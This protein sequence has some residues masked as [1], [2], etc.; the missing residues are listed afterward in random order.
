MAA[1]SP[2]RRPAKLIADD[3]INDAYASQMSSPT[4]TSTGSPTKRSYDGS[5]K[6]EGR[7]QEELE[8]R[9]IV[10]C[11]KSEWPAVDSVLKHLTAISPDLVDETNGYTPLMYALKDGKVARANTFIKLG[12]KVNIRA[13]DGITALHLAASHAREDMIKMLLNQK[14]DP[15][16][17]GGPKGQLPIHILSSRSS[18]S[19]PTALHLLLRSS[20]KEIRLATDRDGNIPLFMA[21]ESGSH[22]ICRE[23]LVSHGKEQVTAR[24]PGTGDTVIHMATR[25]KDLEIL[26][27]A[28]QHGGSVNAQN[29]EGLTPLHLAVIEGDETL[30]RFFHSNNAKPDIIDKHER[31]PLH[32]AAEKGHSHLVEILTDKFKASIFQR[33]KDGSTLMH[34]A[35]ESGHP[36]T[37][38]VF[39]K[40]GVPLQMPN[41][42]GAKGIHMAAAHGYVEVI[43]NL[44]HRG[45]QVDSKT[46]DNLTA[47]HA[48]TM[49]NQAEVLEILLGFG[50]QVQLKG[51][52][53]GE[54]PLHMACRTENGQKCA[55][56]LIKCG[57]DVNALTE[58]G[59]KTPL[60]IVAY[61]GFI[62]TAKLLLEE[63]EIELGLTSEDGESALHIAV[64][65]CHYGIVKLILEYWKKK[66]P[67]ETVCLLVNQQNEEGETPLH[68]AASLTKEMIHTPSE[69]R[70][71]ARVL[72][73]YGANV[74]LVTNNTSET[75]LHYCSQSG[76]VNI[77]EELVSGMSPNEMQTLCN[78]QAKDGWSP[79]LFACQAGTLAIVDFLLK[80][81]ARVDVFD[82]NGKAALHLAAEKGHNDV[83][84]LLLKYKAFINVRSKKGMTPLHMA[85]R[86][87]YGNIV[88]QIITQHGAMLDA[89]TLNKETP[90]HL[91]AERGQL[92]VCN[93]LLELKSDANALDNHGQTPLLLAAQNDH[94]EIVKLFLRHKPELVS[95]ANKDG[96]NCAHIAAMKGSV[97]VIKE[98]MK[99][100]KT[101]I[102]SAKTKSGCTPLHLAAEGGHGDVVQVL[103]QA[104]AS[105][106]EEN[107]DGYTPI[108][109]AAVHGHVSVLQALNNAVSWRIVSKKLGITALH[110][111]ASKGRSDFVREMLTQVPATLTTEQRSDNKTEDYGFTPLH[112][113]AEHGHEDVVRLLLNSAG[114][115]IDAKTQVEGSF[116]I[117]LAARG[118]HMAVVGIIISRATDQIQAKDKDGRTALHL[119]SANGHIKLV[120]LLLGQGADINATDNNG[121]SPVHYASREGY[122]DV[123]YLLTESGATPVTQTKD[124]ATPLACAA[125]TGHYNILKYLLTKEHDS[126]ALIE[127]RKFLVDIMACGKKHDNMPI[128]EFIIASPAPV[129]T[130]V[131]MARSYQL[132]AI[133]EKERSRDL[134][135]AALFCQNIAFDLLSVVS[136]TQNVGIVLRA[137]DSRNMPFLDVL[138]ELQLKEVVAHPAVQSYLS[139]QWMGNLTWATW[140]IL[141]LFLLFLVCPLSWLAFTF[142]SNH[143]YANTPIMKFMSYLV[144][145]IFFILIVCFTVINPWFPIWT[146]T[147]LYPHPHEC[148]LVIWLAGLLVANFTNPRDREGLGWIKAAI[149][150]LGICAIA[151]HLFAFIFSEDRTRQ[152]V[153]Y[154]RNQFLAFLLLLGFLEFLNFLTFHHLFGPWAVI[155]QDLMK[156]LLRFLAILTIFLTGFSLHLCAVYQ[157]V[158]PPEEGISLPTYG[159]EFQSPINTFEMLFF[160]LF[161]LVEP[162]YMPPQHL[163]PGFAK[164]IL[165]IVF[166]VYM[167]VTVVVLINL[168]IAMMSN[169]YQRI[170]AQSDTEWKFGRAKLIRDMNKMLPSPSPMNI[171]A[172]FPYI[173]KKLIEKCK[174]KKQ[175]S[176]YSKGID[177]PGGRGPRVWF[178]KKASRRQQVV[179]VVPV[180]MPEIMNS[181]KHI[182]KVVDWK[183]IVNKYL[184]VQGITIAPCDVPDDKGND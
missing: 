93:I 57:S 110:I 31:T 172:V 58:V 86:N 71:I 48:A 145:H 41:K 159:Q 50:A 102:T 76:N 3:S 144:S 80:H 150:I 6:K 56:L 178:R 7:S 39:L 157:P 175:Q 2:R 107:A 55:E 75:P 66:N 82:E 167:M 74:T 129:D 13:K 100:N 52:K 40:K 149:L 92:Q 156:D 140:K 26:K 15:T 20:N 177:I 176:L 84:E 19:A 126:M 118:G 168:L 142:P 72:L 154:I 59:L 122:M 43:K 137:L 36:D 42:T 161:G 180:N 108:H 45:E 70:D 4:K 61:H 88:R 120:G 165:K 112:I 68:Y 104:G 130:A 91:A 9:L 22:G 143:K 96:F 47:L 119:A 113:A 83:I 182:S 117:H 174:G 60:H 147:T 29:N 106:S 184:E 90:L 49:N 181:A 33:T 99:F 25:R 124:G 38:M 171:I 152:I 133:R 158:F 63:D 32:I 151:V 30:L 54:T 35:S 95:L 67:E 21:V 115:Q 160:A 89:L 5:P 53:D 169:T 135:R 103:L 34:L 116:P 23:L 127:S 101:L 146:S 139:E 114:V 87:G 28:V 138:I 162:D 131:K 8:Q 11:R 105:A 123:V 16:V 94:S 125:S 14:A 78:R 65:R 155:I 27:W 79:L 148:A 111:A 10:L 179:P 77:M 136:S 85:A 17:A 163:S 64:R 44:I 37:A 132:L 121:N 134:E 109:L 164:V 166:G 62:P 12:C 51:G 46:N 173:F 81:G 141:L 98:L 1:R 153:I 18:G 73:E 97:G 183:A 69:D 170:E 24:R 128:L